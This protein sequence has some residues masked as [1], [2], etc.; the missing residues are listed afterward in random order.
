MTSFLDITDETLYR[1]ST[2]TLTNRLDEINWLLDKIRPA[3]P[4]TILP[5]ITKAAELMKVALEHR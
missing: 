1:W 5:G 4:E 3:D 2:T